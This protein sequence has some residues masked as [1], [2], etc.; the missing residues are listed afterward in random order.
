MQDA[1]NADNLFSG[2]EKDHIA[3]E[4]TTTQTLA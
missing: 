1:L 4:S 3:T 2:P